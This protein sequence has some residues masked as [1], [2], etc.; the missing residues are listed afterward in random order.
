MPVHWK[1]SHSTRSVVISAR[2]VIRLADMEEC[3]RAIA[4]PATLSY[5]K[6]V[7]L[8]EAQPALSCEGIVALAAYVREH[9][10][11]G[12]TGAMAIAAGSDEVEQQTRL[13]EALTVADRPVKFFRD[14][15]AARAWLDTQTSP[16]LPPWLEDETPLPPVLEERP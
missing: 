4:M 7:D 11:M 13:F 5:R 10:G 6:L 9:R 3:V 12:P 14:V 16:V 15:E 2:G 1:V 8:V